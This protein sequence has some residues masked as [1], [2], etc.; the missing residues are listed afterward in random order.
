MS[1]AEEA[2]RWF[3][4]YALADVVRVSDPQRRLYRMFG[5]AEASLRDLAHPRVW[6]RWFRTAVIGRH[7]IGSAGPHW[8]QLTG[9]FVIHR[10]AILAAVTHA[11]S[12]A[13]PDYAALVRAVS[14]R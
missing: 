7:G 9:V 10:G 2:D 6:W 3:T 1:S 5:L 12:A 14:V 8:R 13:R 4:R 11:D